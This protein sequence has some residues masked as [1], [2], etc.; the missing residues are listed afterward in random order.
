MGFVVFIVFYFVTAQGEK[1]SQNSFPP[2][3]SKTKKGFSCFFGFG[4]PF[5]FFPNSTAAFPMFSELLG[6]FL[7]VLWV[8]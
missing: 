2:Q 1:K 4:L 5:G 8:L 7:Y 3:A 6:M